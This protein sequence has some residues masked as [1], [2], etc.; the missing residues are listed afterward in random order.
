[1][2][3]LLFSEFAP[4][5]AE[6]GANQKATHIAAKWNP[7]L[8]GRRKLNSDATIFKDD[9][10]GLG[11]VVRDEHG[12]VLMAGSKRCLAAGNSTLAEALAL[13]FGLEKARKARPGWVLLES[14]SETLV[15]NCMGSCSGETHVRMIRSMVNIVQGIEIS[16]CR[17]DANKVAHTLA[18]FGTSPYFEQIWLDEVPDSCNSLILDDVRR[19]PIIC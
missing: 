12:Q 1:M 15:K 3:L 9:T 16:H 6:P 18:R 10:F 2:A 8:P 11:F 5:G 14:D 4:M 19:E 17:R 7:P 13:R